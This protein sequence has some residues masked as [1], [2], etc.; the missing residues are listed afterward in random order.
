MGIARKLFVVLTLLTGALSP[1]ARAQVSAP[2]TEAPPEA[3]SASE[4]APA[5]VPEVRAERVAASPVVDGDVLSDPAWQAAE[6]ATGFWQT[7]PREGEPATERTEVRVLYTDDM[8]YVGVVCYD[9]EP[10]RLIVADTRRDAALD[11]ADSFRFILDTY[12]DG[13]N[14]FVFGTNPAGVEFDAQVSN[15]G[16]GGTGFGRMQAGSGGGLNVNWDGS[17]T[18]KSAVGTYGWSAEFAIPFRTLR[19]AEG[20][21]Q[22]WGINFQRTIRRKNEVAYWS[23]LPRQFD[24]YRVSMA[25]RMEGLVV[26]PTRNLKVMP[27]LMRQADR[28]YTTPETVTNARTE[29]GADLKWSVSPSLTLDVTYNTDFAQVEVDEQQINLDRFSL[30]FPEKRPFFLENAGLFSVGSPGEIELFFSRRIGIGPAGEAVPILGG[31]RLSG[32]VGAY[33]VGLLS[34]RTQSVDERLPGSDFAVARLQ[35]ELPNRSAVGVL[36]TSRSERGD[37]LPGFEPWNRVVAADGRLGIG[38]YG[39]VSGFAARSFSPD[40]G[41]SQSAFNVDAE[42]NSESWLLNAGFAHVEEGFDPEVGFLQRRGYR[43]PS[44]LI[45]HRYR[46]E[47]F[48]G[49]HELRPHISYRGY[50][51]MDGFQET[52]FMHIDNHWEWRSGHELHTGL[53]LTREGVAGPFEIHEGVVVPAGTYD[54]REALIVGFTDR[55]EPVVLSLRTT[56][57][58]FFGGDR[59]SLQPTLNVRLGDTFTSELAVQ[60]NRIDLPGGSFEANLLRTRLSYS[61]TPRIYLQGLFQYNDTSDLWMANLRFGWLQAANTGLFIVLNQSNTVDGFTPLGVRDRSVIVKYSRMFDVLR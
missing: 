19:Y 46:P 7:T 18:V 12:L 23:P 22:A 42:Y 16:Q 2:G 9:D 24:L 13:R 40:A 29:F 51:R 50:W 15:E 20:T 10:D 31:A 36:V 61:F 41:G 58:G 35:R 17:W 25:G 34:M 32:N 14:G 38:R 43:K 30:F 45:F 37:L 8:L 60:H 39:L 6:P 57:G 28:V 5:Q 3:A 1:A 52:G 47:R 21:E 49:F 27:Y 53:N 33:R 44:F 54:H 26:A 11:Q 59:L 56:V 4:G 55:S 48:L